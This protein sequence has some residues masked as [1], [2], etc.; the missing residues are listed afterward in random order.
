MKRKITFFFKREFA[1]LGRGFRSKRDDDE[2]R[3]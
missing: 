2:D 1:D 3:G